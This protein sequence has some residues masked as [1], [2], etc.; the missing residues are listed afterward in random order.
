MH[1]SELSRSGVLGGGDCDP[2]NRAPNKLLVNG[3]SVPGEL[4]GLFWRFK[5]SDAERKSRLV[6]PKALVDPER[7]EHTIATLC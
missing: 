5:A 3:V 7:A 4:G 1:P 6:V 2:S